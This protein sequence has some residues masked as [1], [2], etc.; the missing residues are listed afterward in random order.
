MS[1]CILC[2]EAITNPVCIDCVRDEI[3]AWLYDIKPELYEDLV[4]VTDE[5]NFNYGNVNC[6]LC[7]DHMSICT[8]CYREHILKWLDESSPELVSEF[9]RLFSLKYF[10]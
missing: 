4:R 10:F 5:I 3:A 6:I 8:F 7:K 9:K 2:N 1:E